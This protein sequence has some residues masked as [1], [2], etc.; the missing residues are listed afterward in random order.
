MNNSVKSAW[1]RDVSTDDMIEILR[2]RVDEVAAEN[3]A[4]RQAAR[5]DMEMQAAESMRADAKAQLLAYNVNID[6]ISDRVLGEFS[7]QIHALLTGRLVGLGVSDLARQLQQRSDSVRVAMDAQ[8]RKPYTVAATKREDS[9]GALN[10]SF[11]GRRPAY[12]HVRL[13][14]YRGVAQ[15]TLSGFSDDGDAIRTLGN[16]CNAKDLLGA[17][18]RPEMPIPNTMECLAELKANIDAPNL[19]DYVL[20]VVGDSKLNN[21]DA[22]IAAPLLDVPAL[23]TRD[24]PSTFGRREDQ[25]AHFITTTIPSARVATALAQQINSDKKIPKG[26][27]TTA[28]ASKL[29]ETL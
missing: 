5:S 17:E 8:K 26:L 28:V 2:N 9:L 21:I 22:C 24:L 14:E 1:S 25:L 15:K 12:Q 3:Q 4:H 11:A 23:T 10:V 6:D 18:C 27:K 16:P 13:V 7:L 19:E 29:T 20:I